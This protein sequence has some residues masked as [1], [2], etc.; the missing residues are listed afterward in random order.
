MVQYWHETQAGV[1]E[2]VVNFKALYSHVIIAEESYKVS[3]N[4]LL[5]KVVKHKRKI[6]SQ[7]S[8]AIWLNQRLALL[9]NVVITHQK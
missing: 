9:L 1:S 7:L 3:V 5:L 4:N 8:P 6:K 2:K